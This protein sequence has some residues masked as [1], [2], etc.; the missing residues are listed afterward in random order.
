MIPLLIHYP[1]L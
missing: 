1:G